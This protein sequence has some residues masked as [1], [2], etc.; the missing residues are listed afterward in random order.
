M[1][2]II[3]RHRGRLHR[4]PVAMLLPEAEKLVIKIKHGRGWNLFDLK[5]QIQRKNSL[6]MLNMF[7]WQ[8]GR[9]GSMSS[10][11]QGDCINYSH[12][13]ASCLHYV[14]AVQRNQRRGKCCFQLGGGGGMVLK[15]MVKLLRNEKLASR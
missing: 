7:R 1:W 14:A 9:V 2:S 15:A 4:L 3:A 10:H 8:L 11:H 12:G 6:G 5:L 13:A